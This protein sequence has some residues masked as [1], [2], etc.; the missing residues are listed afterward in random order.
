MA[1]FLCS[2]LEKRDEIGINSFLAFIEHFKTTRAL[3]GLRTAV[4][5]LGEK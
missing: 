3:A 5:S 1:L 2:V 4:R